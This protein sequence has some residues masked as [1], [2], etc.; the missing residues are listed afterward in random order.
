MMASRFDP[1][2][3]NLATHPEYAKVTSTLSRA[4]KEH[5]MRFSQQGIDDQLQV[6]IM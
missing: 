2:N 3:E 1:E 5:W 4:I 6:S